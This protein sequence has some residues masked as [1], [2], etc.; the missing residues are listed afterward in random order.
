MGPRRAYDPRAACPYTSRSLNCGSAGAARRAP[1][2]TGLCALT[3]APPGP[4]CC[5][6]KRGT[7]ED[8]PAEGDRPFL[9]AP[10]GDTGACC[11]T[12]GRCTHVRRTQ[13]TQPPTSI[14]CAGSGVCLRFDS[15]GPAARATWPPR[16]RASHAH[17]PASQQ[18]VIVCSVRTGA[19]ACQSVGA[20]PAFETSGK[21]ASRMCFRGRAY[22]ADPRASRHAPSPVQPS[23]HTFHSAAARR[24]ITGNITRPR[25]CVPHITH[26]C[27]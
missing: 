10:C 6:P 2:Y 27:L 23:A 26:I 7:L 16:R 12:C 13:A 14:E 20:R 19:P 24:R 3:Y 1:V 11:T 21:C 22:L 17:R 18:A 5:H 8:L 25:Q 4:R 15:A 9:C